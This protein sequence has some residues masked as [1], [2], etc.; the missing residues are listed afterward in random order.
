MNIQIQL[1]GMLILVLLYVFYKSNARLQL[2]TERICH[3]TMKVAIVSLALDILSI[4]MIVNRHRI[5]AIIVNGVCKIYIVS[6]VWITMLAL[7]YVLTDLFSEALHVKGTKIMVAI[8]VLQSLLVC[9]LP[10]HIFEEG[11]IVYTYGPAVLCVYVF[12]AIYMIVT[13]AVIFKYIQKMNKR[14]VISVCL[15]MS[16]WIAAALIQFLNNELLIVGFAS[17][18]GILILFVVIENPEANIDRKL[19]CFNSYALTEYVELLIDRGEE[20]CLLEISF[21]KLEAL[22]E[23]EIDMETIMHKVIHLAN[24]YADIKFFKNI[25]SDFLIIGNDSK[26]LKHLGEKVLKLLEDYDILHKDATVVLV[27]HGNSFGKINDLFHFM[28]FVRNRYAKDKSKVFIASK[29]IILKYRERYMIET[30]ISDALEQDR[31]E[32]FYQPIYSNKEK[33]FTSAEALVR[34]RNT[35]G[36]LLPPGI[37]IPV[38]EKSGQIVDLGDR[39]FEKVCQ[40]L[41]S[42]ESIELGIHYIE[43]NLSVVQCEMDDLA[44]RLISIIEKYKVD[45]YLINLEITETASIHTRT[46]LENNMKKLIDYGFTFSLDDFGKGE[47]NLMY[48]VQMP[49]SLVKLDYDMSKAFFNSEKARHVVRAVINMAHKMNMKLVAEG[50]ET[51]DEMD[52]MSQEGIDYIQGYY[53]AKPLPDKEFLNFIEENNNDSQG[54]DLRAAS[55]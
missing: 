33:R 25:N 34:I 1:C 36:S 50:I 44:E 15:W 53:Y 42:L 5:P 8:T 7:N 9:L 27:L 13:M 32:V 11:A 47:S 45:P 54:V 4:I 19:G 38:A 29:D 22:E 3:R 24:R 40:F 26:K 52:N 12:V 41:K 20:F 16:I 2:Y 21:G 43:V 14:R 39:V 31:V 10:I 6:L 49:V 23:Y 51:K 17:A 37:F 30:Q 48:M 55:N 35:D 28:T 18:I 46:V